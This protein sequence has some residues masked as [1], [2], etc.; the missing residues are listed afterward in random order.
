MFGQNIIQNTLSVASPKGSSGNR[1]Y[2]S[3]S[4]HHSKVACWAIIFDLLQTC[5]TLLEHV[6]SDK[7]FI[8]IN[9][10]I[11]DF[12]NGKSKNLD[13]VICLPGSDR[14]FRD[15]FQNMVGKHHIQ[16]DPQ[17]R[18]QFNTLPILRRREVG[19]VLVALEAK[20]CMTAH[21]KSWPRLYDELNSSHNIV[22]GASD[23]SVAAGYVF[24]NAAP[25]HSST[26]APFKV[27]HHNQPD[28]TFGTI[29]TIK[30]LRRRSGTGQIGYDALGIS[31][32]DLANDGSPVR[33]VPPPV[34]LAP[35][36]PL[37][38]EQM[39]QRICSA[40]SSRFKNI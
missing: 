5:P 36:D 31:V 13:L 17:E 30:Q 38:Y 3:R 39:I 19:T 28:D 14:Q 18:A 20:A 33:I 34:G 40:Y 25:T 2:H 1:Q 21:Q 24:V 32:I 35:T 27:N 26:V 7:V 16:L 9:H 29:D 15:T 23:D 8:G 10:K 12:T 6:G 22:H 37:S 4:D 11:N